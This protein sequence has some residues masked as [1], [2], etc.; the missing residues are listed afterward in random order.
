MM[1]EKKNAKNIQWVLFSEYIKKK[2]TF[3]SAIE[4]K[5]YWVLVASFHSNQVFFVFPVSFTRSIYSEFNILRTYLRVFMC[6]KHSVSTCNFHLNAPYRKVVRYNFQ[7]CFLDAK[8][9]TS[10]R[11]D[12]LKLK[13]CHV[14]II[15]KILHKNRISMA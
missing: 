13:R 1:F 3:S 6:L 9:T 8:K 2:R 7:N 14:Q 15:D 5:F 11:F 4:R 10:N 12:V